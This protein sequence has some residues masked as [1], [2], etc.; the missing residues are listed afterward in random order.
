MRAHKIVE[1]AIMRNPGG[2]VVHGAVLHEEGFRI[3]R[4]QRL[5]CEWVS[6]YRILVLTDY[7]FF[8][9]CHQR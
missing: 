2:V 9:R 1:A 8:Y 7:S 5:R 3:D 4:K 6:H